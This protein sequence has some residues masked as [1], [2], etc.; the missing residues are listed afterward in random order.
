MTTVEQ[1]RAKWKRRLDEWCKLG[2]QLSGEQLAREVLADIEQLEG[3]DERSVSLQEAHAIGGYSVDHLQR[4]VASEA[5]ENVGRKGKPRIRRSDVPV[6][7][8]HALH[9]TSDSASLP[10]SRRD[11]VSQVTRSST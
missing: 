4:L 3:V 11:V 7:P 10:N 9:A 2:V 6:K 8:G 1:L 5:I